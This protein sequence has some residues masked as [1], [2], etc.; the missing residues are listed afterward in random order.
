MYKDFTLKT[1]T[2][3]LHQRVHYYIQS[4]P[5]PLALMWCPALAR[6]TTRSGQTKPLSIWW[7]TLRLTSCDEDNSLHIVRRNIEWWQL[8]N[9][10]Q[11]PPTTSS[12]DQ[13]CP[14]C[15]THRSP[16][17]PKVWVRIF[18][19]TQAYWLCCSHNSRGCRCS[20]R[21]RASGS[22]YIHAKETALPMLGALYDSGQESGS[23]QL[24]TVFYH[25][26]IRIAPTFMI[27]TRQRTY[28]LQKMLYLLEMMERRQRR[29]NGSC[30]NFSFTQDS[31]VQRMDLVAF[32]G[33]GDFRSEGLSITKTEQAQRNMA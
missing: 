18:I 15:T 23:S 5:V 1:D 27:G 22:G 28:E 25:L 19:Q 10:P 32:G 9:L 20:H 16:Q 30:A 33:Y 4:I 11:D 8:G 14:S 2:Q 31:S 13:L 21:Q 29:M 26:R 17:D 24:C 3:H 7:F 12:R 6:S